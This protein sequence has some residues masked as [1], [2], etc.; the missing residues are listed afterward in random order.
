MIERDRQL[1]SFYLEKH[2]LQ[3][4]GDRFGLTRERAR[5]ILNANGVKPR[6]WTCQTIR[7]PF[8]KNK[9]TTIERFWQ[10]VDKSGGDDACWLWTG[11]RHKRSG[12]GLFSARKYAKTKYAH[13]LSYLFSNHKR[14]KNNVL[15]RCDNKPCVNPK[16]LYDGTQQQNVDD[17]MARNG[18]SWL[19]NLRASRATLSPNQV[20]DIKIRL[21]TEHYTVIAKDYLEVCENTIYMIDKGK[22][23]KDIEVGEQVLTS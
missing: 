7:A 11:S 23:W 5:Q 17:R 2:T 20:R 9:L 12:Y 22:S 14:A 21:Q 6:K 1:I 18:E 3:E 19:A 13:K 4:C 10:N 8:P 16:H 15:H